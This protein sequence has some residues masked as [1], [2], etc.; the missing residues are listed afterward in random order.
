MYKVIYFTDLNIVTS[1]DFDDVDDA[2]AFAATC[3]W[4][5]IVNMTESRTIVDVSLS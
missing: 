3:D 4:A 2:R 5:K 1:R